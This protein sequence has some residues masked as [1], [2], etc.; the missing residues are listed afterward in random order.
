MYYRAPFLGLQDGPHHMVPW[1]TPLPKLIKRAS[2]PSRT[3]HSERLSLAC[4][5]CPGLPLCASAFLVSWEWQSSPTNQA[6][7]NKGSIIR[8]LDLGC[9]AKGQRLRK[10]GKFMSWPFHLWWGPYKHSFTFS[11]WLISLSIIPSRSIHFVTNGKILFFFYC[12]VIFHYIYVP[13]LLYPLV[14]NIYVNC[15][16]KIC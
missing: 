16:W 5:L 7:Q 15:N 3:L 4:C 1:A 14:Y 13:Q 8:Y 9:R 6:A 12:W 11:V 2:K 10:P